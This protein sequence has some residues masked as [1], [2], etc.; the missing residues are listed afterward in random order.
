MDNHL[1]CWVVISL[2][3]ENYFVLKLVIALGF[4]VD[5]V[6]IVVIKVCFRRSRISYTTRTRPAQPT[7]SPARLHKPSAHHY[8][9]KSSTSA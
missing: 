7:R 2:N 5:F 9:I 6:A 4:A 3:L 1:N 8:S